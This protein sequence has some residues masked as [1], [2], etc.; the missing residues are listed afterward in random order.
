MPVTVPIFRPDQLFGGLRPV[1]E[2]GSMQTLNLRLVDPQGHQYVLRSVDKDL[3]RALPDK[4]KKG[5][6]AHLLQDQT[7]AVHPYGA[8][9]A[10]ELAQA[11]GVLHA[12]P[13]LYRVPTA[14]TGLGEFETAF[15]GRLVFLE[16]RP[17]GNWQG[18]P[19]FGGSK[20][21]VSSAV[22]LAERYGVPGT[23]VQP[24]RLDLNGPAPA[25]AYLRAR[26]LDILLADWSRREDQWRWARQDAP[27]A[28]NVA[29]KS[30]A[31]YYAI[32]R[33]RDHAFSRYNDGVFPGL[34][35]LFKPKV[36]S[37]GPKIGRVNRYHHTADLLDH[38][39]LGWRAQ[40]DFM[41]EADSLVRRLSDAAID[42]A[43]TRMPPNIQR[44]DGRRLRQG[45]QRRRDQLPAAARQ[46]YAALNR[47]A[48]LPGSDG[49]DDYTLSAGPNDNLT[50]TWTS[51]VDST[52]R[53]GASTYD[54]TFSRRETKHLQL[55]GLGGGDRLILTG[56]LPKDGPRV[57][58]F[59]GP[60]R[61]EA[62]RTGGGDTPR[63]LKVRASGD[64][65]HF[66]ALP[67]WARKGQK[68]VEA[69]DFDAN[70]FLLR[71]RL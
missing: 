8:L 46:L 38:V 20:K 30:T 71:H 17:E 68:K 60:G 11:A 33:D 34:V 62:R 65:N 31:R 13:R 52:R 44:L 57:E 21:V 10:A 36:V 50:V 6:K 39:V 29:G 12:T 64:E 19:V 28:E 1:K 70:G 69:R 35:V 18:Q 14:G 67:D 40:A 49:S 16:E 2:G 25:R 48:V 3:T 59:D 63:W 32:P 7:A 37:F 5:M 26:L 24:P 56:P 47:E 45:L 54:R 43:L 27:A 4:Q 41:A 53:G 42:R 66:E 9:V 23:T 51:H 61:D 22:L 58:F 15:A 55:H